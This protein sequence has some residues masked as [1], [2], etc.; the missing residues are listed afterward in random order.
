[1]LLKEY[2]PGAK[3]VA[4]NE[5]QVRPCRHHATSA[6]AVCTQ[7]NTGACMPWMPEPSA[8]EIQDLVPACEHGMKLSIWTAHMRHTCTPA[9]LMQAALVR[10]DQRSVCMQV[11]KRL[12]GLP[13][14]KW[15]AATAPLSAEVPVVP[16]LG[17]PRALS[18]FD[19]VIVACHMY[20]CVP[21]NRHP[22]QASGRD[23]REAWWCR[24][25]CAYGAAAAYGFTPE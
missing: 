2:L 9:P 6:S 17:R 10:D 15:H 5:V 4:C 13:R 21:P 16:L 23:N 7:R 1:M 18:A 22:V 11:L 25:L 8:R 24:C 12:A 19:L 3:S 14:R 20:S